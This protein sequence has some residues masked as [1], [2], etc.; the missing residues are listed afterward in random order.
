M[1]A[2]AAGKFQD[3]YEVLGI[4][5]KADDD[6]IRAA[7][8]E[9]SR[10]HAGDAEKLGSLSLALEVL[11]DPDLRRGFN[12]LKGIE[13]Q[14]VVKFSADFFDGVSRDAGVRMTLLCL[15]YDRRRTKSYTPSI[16]NRQLEAMLE[17]APEEMAFAVWYLKQRSLVTN[18]DKSALQITVAGI[19][20]VDRERPQA[21]QILPFIKE[22]FRS[23]PARSKAAANI[24]GM[25]RRD[26]PETTPN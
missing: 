14:E 1:S 24:M 26:Q 8:A 22:S 6:A 13:I 5:P 12:K 23:A 15:L 25:L 4:D 19:D 3:H 10:K 7:H 16:S 2:P 18:D 17:V 9:L 20:L 21:D 11:T